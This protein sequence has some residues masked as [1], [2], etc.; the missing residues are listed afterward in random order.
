MA[1]KVVQADFQEQE[2]LLAYDSLWSMGGGFS[3][4]VYRPMRSDNGGNWLDDHQPRTVGG[5]RV[6][7]TGYDGSRLL[8]KSCGSC[9]LLLADVVPTAMRT[10]LKRIGKRVVPAITMTAT[11]LPMITL[12]LK[13]TK[14]ERRKSFSP[15]ID[16]V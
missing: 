7:P 11:T 8:C 12:T 4:G 14:T 2:A 1:I 6:N 9:R 13:K 16:K 5:K 3:N 15:T 10:C